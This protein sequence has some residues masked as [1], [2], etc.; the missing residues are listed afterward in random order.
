MR[1]KSLEIKGF[2]SFADKTIVNFDDNITGIVGPNGCGKSNIVDSI[3]WVIGEQKIS[4]LR[5]ENLDSLVFNG[6]KTRSASGLAE[7]SLTF[8]NTRNLLPT[9]F[10]TVTITRKFYKSGESEYRLNDVQCRLKDIQNLFMDTGISTDSYA[11]IEL[12]M[13]DD[14]I[15]DKENSRRRMLEQAAGISIY[16]ARKKEAK[17]KLDATEQDLAR[18]EDL[19]FEINNQLKSLESQAKKAEK[20]HEIKKDYREISIELAKAALEGFNLTYRELNEQHEA[21]TDKR[22]RMEAEIA[23]EE[24]ALEQEKVGFIEKERQLQSMQHAFN[25]LV[26][27]V[28]TKENEKNLAAQRLEYLK[29]RENS[30]KE[31]LQKAEG[32]LKGIDES[33]G[34]TRQQVEEESTALEGLTE[35]LQQLNNEVA[36]QREVLDEKRRSLDSL[37]SEYQQVQRNQF[38]A[39]KKV[40]VA[41]TSVQNLQRTIGQ[42]EEERKQREGDR[43]H[44]DQER[45]LKEKEL[46]I[47]KIDLEQ[48]QQHQENTREQI[49]QTQSIVESLRNELAEETRKLDSKKNEHD[50]LKSMIDSMEGYPDSV[51]FLHNNN[52][53]NHTSPILSDILYVKEEYRTA[54]E[55]VL[56]PYLSYYVV[57]DLPEGLQAVH[58]LDENKKGKANFFLLDKVNANENTISSHELDGAIRALNVVEV[59]EKYRKLAEHL[60]GNVFIADGE[61]ALQ[62][63]NGFVVIEKDGKYV[64]GKYSLTGGSVG[65]IEGK[66]IGRVKNL[67]KLQEEIAIQDEVVEK[68]RSEIQSRHNE[69]IAFNED[70]RENAVRETEKEIQQLTNQ[71]FSLHN[72]LENLHS[73]QTNSQHR[74]EEMNLQM[75]QTQHSVEGVRNQLTEYNEQLQ[76]YTSKLA[77]AE[78]NFKAAEA[79]FNEAS[80]QYNEFNLNVTRQQSKINALKQELDFK[81]NQLNDLQQQIESNTTSLSDTITSIE[82]SSASLKGIEDGLVEMMRRR[83]EEQTILNEADQAYYNLRNLLS[84]KESELRHKVKD[85][86]QVEHLLAAIKDKLNDLKLQLAGTKERLDV[87]FRIKLEDILDQ[88][89]TTE[90]ALEELQEKADRMKKRLE[91]LGEVNPTAI[92]AFTEMKKRYE[93]IVEQKNDLVSAKDSLLK[94]IEEVEASANQKFLETFNK[95]RENFIKVFKTLFTEDDDADLVLENPENLA[96]TGIDVMARPKGKRPT[97]LTQLSGGER[98]LTATALLFAIY[99]IKPAPFCI[100]DEVDAPL[101]DANVGK[102]T[103]MI[104]QFSDNSQFIIVTHNKM[105]MSTVDVIYGVT[106]QEPGVSKLVSVDFRNLEQNKN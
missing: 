65:M 60:L 19:L 93:F 15:K 58:L 71:V 46:N 50:L 38:D 4:H 82:Q 63:S 92:E 89:R 102:F 81:S 69:V 33:I 2:K 99:L 39:E 55:N 67:E 28:R 77:E 26:Q 42:I 53:W 91:N 16:K 8:E 12:G 41:D 56:E 18:I 86:E 52:N 95:V 48:L 45:I 75:Q 62:N 31:F 57:N 22:I 88:A 94:T 5:S 105:T 66:K 9:E 97:S 47:K 51:K 64:K 14:L 85:K 3:R 100:L 29:E 90:T 20:Y 34:F 30:L 96:E 76:S 35:Q 83:E 73:M 59:E 7:V 37:R 25:E 74:L 32:Q 101:D 104:R 103:N 11:I 61:D 68:L 40:A 87:E 36:R 43:H 54:L 21:E 70:L 98:T 80:Q 24:A 10:S 27:Q 17:L 84:E 13:V 72:K 79:T 6:S 49:L 1:L 44:L 23:N 78:E 106:M